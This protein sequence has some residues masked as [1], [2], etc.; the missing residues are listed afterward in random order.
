MLRILV[1]AEHDPAPA[2]QLLVAAALTGN[3]A[4]RRVEVERDPFSFVV[5]LER[6]RPTLADQLA[7]LV[8]TVLGPDVSVSVSVDVRDG[9][10]VRPTA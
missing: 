6:G 5:D 4:V 9:V 10:P 2:E 3:P 7:T 8:A 1:T